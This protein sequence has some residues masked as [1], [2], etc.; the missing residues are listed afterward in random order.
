MRTV[1]RA[2]FS[3]PPSRNRNGELESWHDYGPERDTRNDALKDRVPRAEETLG[4]RSAIQTRQTTEWTD[5]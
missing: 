5:E 2:K 4:W 1:Y 3:Y